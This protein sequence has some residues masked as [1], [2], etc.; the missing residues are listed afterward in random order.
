M[1]RYREI[2]EKIIEKYLVLI[3]Q[4]K[5][6]ENQRKIMRNLGKIRY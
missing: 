5:M 2:F 6:G 4:E 1:N 3:Y